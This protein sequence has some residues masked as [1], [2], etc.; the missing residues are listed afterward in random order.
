MISKLLLK[1]FKTHKNTELEFSPGINIVTGDTGQGKTNIL[2]ALQLVK[3]N[4]PL[5]SG[6]IR[7]GQNSTSVTMEV[8]DGKNTCGVVR[9]R[10]KSENIYDIEKNGVSIVGDEPLTAFG[11]SP[12]KE[13]LEILN[14]SDIN[15]QKQR[16]Q[17][18]LVYSPPG[19][20]ATYIRSITKLDEIDQ[21]TKSLSS[22]IRTEGGKIS[23]CQ[24][25][26]K[27]TNNELAVLNKIDLELLENKIVEAKDTVLKIKQIKEKIERIG[28]IVKAL[29]TLEE[30]RIYI[31]DNVDK[32]FD[33][34][35]FGQESIVRV[36]S[37]LSN[38]EI[39]IDKI[40]KIEVRRIVLPEDLTVL[41]DVED[42]LEKHS[43]I[44]EKTEILHRLLEDIHSVEL[45][46]E[47]NDKRLEQVKDEE[48]QLMEELT[49]CP[50]CG[51]ELTEE[52]KAVLLER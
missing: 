48:K 52:S 28:S 46:I 45:K 21:V 31:P 26:L 44:C 38:L 51:V 32:I 36:S 33:A 42:A 19:Q 11:N 25:E 20:I 30:N 13:V 16:D 27:S 41:S 3:D 6:Y 40:K 15:V 22:K 2:L 37:R 43:D 5:G 39:L 12:P 9:R 49:S 14:L 29:R 4:R 50:S 18:F 23:H 47:D 1:D 34:I 7:R 17:H 24:E 10:G 8:V 35:E